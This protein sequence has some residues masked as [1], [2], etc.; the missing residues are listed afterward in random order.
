MLEQKVDTVRF[1]RNGIIRRRGD[2]V[3][4][5]H[6]QFVAAH[7]PLVGANRPGHAQRRL[8]AEVLEL[9]EQLPGDFALLD[10]ALTESRP[11]ANDQ[12][13]NLPARP[14]VVQ[15]AFQR[16]LLP[17]VV[18]QLLDRSRIVIRHLVVP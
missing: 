1:R 12:E 15:P 3:R 6:G 5:G 14:A 18:F 4:I 16:H 7:A 10:D 17:C 8:L 2:D 13:L 9:L 11:V